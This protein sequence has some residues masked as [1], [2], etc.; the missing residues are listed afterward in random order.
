M[1]TAA[2]SGEATSPADRVRGAAAAVREAVTHVIGGGDITSTIGL[3]REVAAAEDVL[4]EFSR[5][6]AQIATWAAQL[7]DRY[8]EAPFGTDALT[9]AVNRVTDANRN[10][11]AIKDA[12]TE[13]LAALDEADSLGETVTG[14]RAHGRIDAFRN[15]G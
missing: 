1:T 15:V 5:L 7:P 4:E 8:A 11:D 13:M 3:R 10:A 6:I 9:T 12:L 2:H 14:I